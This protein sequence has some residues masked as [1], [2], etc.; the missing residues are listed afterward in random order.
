MSSSEVK[1]V[2]SQF[3]VSVSL[4]MIRFNQVLVYFIR[5]W[6]FAVLSVILVSQ[7]FHFSNFSSLLFLTKLASVGPTDFFRSLTTFHEWCHDH[8]PRHPSH[9]NP[10]LW[11]Q[12][13]TVLAHQTNPYLLSLRFFFNFTS[14]HNFS[15]QT[16]A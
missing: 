10:H 5:L 6:L 8:P 15:H 3:S 16:A 14:L 12:T 7:L 13:A 4:C 11:L 9:T 1:K 2:C